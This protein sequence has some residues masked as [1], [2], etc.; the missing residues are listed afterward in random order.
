ME[1]VVTAHEMKKYDRNTSAHF[2]IS[3][4]VLMERAAIAFVEEIQRRYRNKKRILI[5]AGVGNN[6][7]DGIAIG[8]I[9]AQRGYLVTLVFP[10]DGKRGSDET[11]IQ[12]EIYRKYGQKITDKMPK[13]EYDIIIDA[14]F[15]IGLNRK[16]EGIYREVITDINQ[17][18]G[19]KIAVDIPSG[20]DADNG[21]ILGVCVKADITVTFAFKK[22]GMILYPGAEYCGKIICKDIG[23]TRAS[24]LDEEPLMYSY[25][26]DDIKRLPK[27]NKAGNKGSFGKVLLLAG[28]VNMSGACVLAGLSAYRSGT[29]LVRIVTTGQ[30]REIIQKMLPEAILITYDD[31]D[32]TIK[33]EIIEGMKWADCIVI[34]PGLG[35][36]E[37]AYH[38]LQMVLEQTKTPLVIDADA[39]NL[40]ADHEILQKKVCENTR[41]GAMIIMTPHMG[42]FSRLT[43]IPIEALKD[44]R[45]E[46][47]LRYRQR[48]GVTLVCKD[49]R[50]IC[51][52]ICDGDERERLYMNQS[53]NDGMATAGSGD[54]LA[55][56]IGSM[57]AQK[58]KAF[59][60]ACLGVYIHGLAGDL[61]SKSSN[62]YSMIASDMI[63]QL[64]YIL[65]DEKKADNNYETL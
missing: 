32:M 55:G 11:K 1:Y 33:Q 60:A 22:R 49:A 18:A 7:G 36:S 57:V 46:H 30:N 42:E 51:C 16:V 52:G 15:G 9:L 6:G 53:G 21:R 27:R 64:K 34:G 31:S 23:I 29:G 63:E 25:Q 24:F 20:L 19:I 3:S 39:L 45:I 37:M 62:R 35:K 41:L 40:I 56:I 65:S 2:G 44:H 8:R 17:R 61:A 28:S 58:L 47:I 5:V 59:E 14:V 54:V 4:L 12:L 43:K 38:L 48:Y 10:G 50:T 26:A 13:R